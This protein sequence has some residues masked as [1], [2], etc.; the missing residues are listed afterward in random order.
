M[1]I[2]LLIFLFKISFLFFVGAPPPSNLYHSLSNS[3]EPFTPSYH[4]TIGIVHLNEM[5]RAGVRLPNFHLINQPRVTRHDFTME[6]KPLTYEH[7][8]LA[9]TCIVKGL[10]TIYETNQNQ[11]TFTLQLSQFTDQL[12]YESTE[13]YRNLDY[14]FDP[15][16]G[17]RS[18]S[19]AEMAQQELDKNKIICQIG[20]IDQLKNIR[21]FEHD[22]I[23]RYQRIFKEGIQALPESKKTKYLIPKKFMN[24]LKRLEKN[25]QTCP[26]PFFVEW[27][28]Y[29]IEEVEKE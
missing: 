24:E 2:F 25:F 11:R 9:A 18:K 26:N 14:Y 17:E 5:E 21:H 23:R 27:L 28:H 29:K 10:C 19:W 20:T 6:S 8:T 4:I 12:T 16:T 22:K 13:A 3:T 7:Y 15:M 1:L